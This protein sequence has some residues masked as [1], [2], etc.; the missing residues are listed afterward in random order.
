MHVDT[1]YAACDQAKGLDAACLSGSAMPWEPVVTM[2]DQLRVITVTTPSGVTPS[3]TAASS[4]GRWL[5]LMLPKLGCVH[6]WYASVLQQ[7]C[8]VNAY[9]TAGIQLAAGSGSGYIS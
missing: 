9:L 6:K 2:Q 1:L 8:E 4:N 3:L 7:A 5:Q